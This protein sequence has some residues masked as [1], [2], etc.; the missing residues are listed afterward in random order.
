MPRGYFFLHFLRTDVCWSFQPDQS[1]CSCFGSWKCCFLHFIYSHANMSI[2]E[3][4][5]LNIRCS[6]AMLS[7]SIQHDYWSLALGVTAKGKVKIAFWS[8]ILFKCWSN[9]I[10]WN[11]CTFGFG[12]L[13]TSP[14]K[15]DA[16]EIFQLLSIIIFMCTDIFICFHMPGQQI[17]RYSFVTFCLFSAFWWN[18]KIILIVFFTP[19]YFALWENEISSSFTLLLEGGKNAGKTKI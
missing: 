14:Q 1:W 8:G 18:F 4:G 3:Y 10:L 12:H 5:Y 9:L 16:V 2:T 13:L 6:F 19:S 17:I 11:Q 7:W 15:L